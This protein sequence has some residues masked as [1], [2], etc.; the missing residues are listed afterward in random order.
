MHKKTI[1]YI[2]KNKKLITITIFSLLT[3]IISAYVNHIYNADSL[4]TC[5]FYIPVVM[6]G[7]WYYQYTIHLSIF[8]TLYINFL[9]FISKDGMN[10]D[11]I[12]RGLSMITGAIVLYCLRK[13]L[14]KKNEELNISKNLLLH[15]KEL[16]STMLLSIG[17]GV[18][19]T[20]KKGNIIFL[21]EAAKELTGWIKESA[22]GRS[23]NDVFHV[24]DE[25]T[26][27]KPVDL[28]SEGLKTSKNIEA[29]KDNILVSKNGKEIYIDVSISPLYDNEDHI[30]GIVI[31]F[32]DI[33]EVQVQINEIEYLSFHDPLTGLGNRRYLEKNLLKFNK[34]ESLPLAVIMGDVNGLKP[35]NDTFGHNKGDNLLEEVAKVLRA[36]CRVD[37]IIC[38]YGGDEFIIL[39]PKTN[40]SEVVKIVKRIREAF[41]N[42][43][44]GP[45]DVSMSLGWSVKNNISEDIQE[46]IKVAENYMYKN[47]FF[48]SPNIR[49]NIVHNIMNTL[50]ENSIIEGG[51]S[52]RTGESGVKIAR[53]LNQSEEEL[54]KYRTACLL[55]D[56]GKIAIDKEIIT[57]KTKL[58]EEEWV[59][60]KRHPEIGYRI[61]NAV[62]E[63][64]EI[65]EYILAHHERWDGKGYPKGLKGEEIPYISRIISLCDSYDA[66][67]SDRPYRKG[68]SEDEAVDEI[69]K[70]AGTQFDPDIAKLFVEEVLG[71]KWE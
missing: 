20:D 12:L 52:E 22:I 69:K 21:N 17:D 2:K 29:A 4:Y 36:A 35:T 41:S 71:K 54:E 38:R 40:E 31:V 34:E 46:T 60:I 64:A 42:V 5:L 6:T 18:I 55:H 48:E 28:L 51:H 14:N 61:L 58:T 27:E 3:C 62:P 13:T 25:N 39:L 7:L 16:L 57:K 32:R 53:A 11:Q 19:S 15:E 44:I 68:M 24:I 50:K 70:C 10:I 9:D 1:K 63:Y 47:K 23:I 49:G 59:T 43:K 33:T 65:S 8:F 45:I 56:I 66:M 37:D 67:I 26:R 30:N